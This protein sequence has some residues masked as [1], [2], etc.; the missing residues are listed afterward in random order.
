MSANYYYIVKA[1][2]LQK[3]NNLTKESEDED[4]GTRQFLLYDVCLICV[5]NMNNI[6]MDSQEGAT[7]NADGTKGRKS[8]KNFPDSVTTVLRKWFYDH[9]LHPYP[10]DY[11]KAELAEKTGLT[12]EQVSYW[13]V[14][15]RKRVWQPL[16]RARRSGSA[17]QVSS[18]SDTPE[19]VQT[20]HPSCSLPTATRNGGTEHHAFSTPAQ[21]I[22]VATAGP[23][24]DDHSMKGSLPL[25]G[26]RKR[27]REEEATYGDGLRENRH[28]NYT[29]NAN[30]SPDGSSS[31]LQSLWTRTRQD[32]GNGL[33]SAS[34]L[35]PLPN[36][37]S[38]PFPTS[39]SLSSA[40]AFVPR[41]GLEEYLSMGVGMT[42]QQLMMGI[43]QPIIPWVFPQSVSKYF[44]QDSSSLSPTE[45]VAKRSKK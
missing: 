36:L 6:S 33:A 24:Y 14:N 29:S 41:I 38:L 40:H 22:T 44:Y 20:M 25:E 12:V 31:L 5:H 16:L 39:L 23:L 37:G 18:T 11:E 8:R 13:F 15:Q 10:E 35:L 27:S 34:T 2:A 43:T 7:G 21:G 45:N 19:E 1:T 9:F 4:S 26:T 42:T 32:V 30:V 3:M 17:A 28:E